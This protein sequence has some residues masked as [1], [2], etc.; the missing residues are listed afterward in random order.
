MKIQVQ[1]IKVILENIYM[2]LL[3]LDVSVWWASCCNM[4]KSP[5]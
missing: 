4:D 3:K 5:W 2:K 1:S